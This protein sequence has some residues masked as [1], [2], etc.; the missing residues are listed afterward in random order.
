MREEWSEK[1]VKKF[2]KRLQEF[3]KIVVLFPE[4]Y[5]TSKGDLKRAVLSKHNSVLYQID[6]KKQLIR[7]ITIF[8]NRQHPS[9]LK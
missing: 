5:A 8:D 4:L 2:I 7:V 6:D 9:K 1:E 3:E